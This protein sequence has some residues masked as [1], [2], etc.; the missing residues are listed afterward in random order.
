MNDGDNIYRPL[1]AVMIRRGNR[2]V[3]GI[4]TKML[5][6]YIEGKKLL[7][8]DSISGDGDQ[9]TRLDEHFQLAKYFK[10]ETSSKVLRDAPSPF[11]QEED[12]ELEED[13]ICLDEGED[14]VVRPS[15]P[16]KFENQLTELAKMLKDLNK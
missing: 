8:T 7:R 2:V 3:K 14:S 11:P 5:V 6:P 4:P 1:I 15:R 10:D 13:P 16:P 12:A 9:W